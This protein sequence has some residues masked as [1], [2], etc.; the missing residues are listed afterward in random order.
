MVVL[1]NMAQWWNLWRNYSFFIDL[2]TVL[3]TMKIKI[4]FHNLLFQ[5]ASFFG[6]QVLVTH[7][8]NSRSK[9]Y[10]Y[11]TKWFH[12]FSV[13]SFSLLNL[14]FVW[15]YFGILQVEEFLI[16]PKTSS[17]PNKYCSTS[18]VNIYLLKKLWQFF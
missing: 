15:S 17:K 7:K 3:A 18:S 2:V 9:G 4:W 14:S 5:K 8:K 10:Y 6:R 1:S 11:Q 12:G 13:L 16:P